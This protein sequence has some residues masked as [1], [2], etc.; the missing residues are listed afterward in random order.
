MLRAHRR[1]LNGFSLCCLTSS[2]AFPHTPPHPVALR[3]TDT[4]PS[5][6]AEWDHR[7]LTRSTR[8][9]VTGFQGRGSGSPLFATCSFS[10]FIFLA[11]TRFFVPLWAS[12]LLGLS[13]WSPAPPDSGHEGH[14]AT[15]RPT[16]QPPSAASS[17][18]PPL[19]R[20]PSGPPGAGAEKGHPALLLN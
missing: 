7:R 17:L 18:G 9:T 6:T 5:Y 13:L 8:H 19:V 12:W 14:A 16:H 20:T 3:A 4:C 10:P 11:R 1:R 2:R 15:R